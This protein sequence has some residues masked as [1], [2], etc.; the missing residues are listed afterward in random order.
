MS[1]LSLGKVIK[2]LPDPTSKLKFEV[3]QLLV[4]FAV[5]GI[6]YILIEQGWY[7]NHKS[8]GKN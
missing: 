6:Y 7:I 2:V 1:L 8:A 5:G 3:Q 4:T